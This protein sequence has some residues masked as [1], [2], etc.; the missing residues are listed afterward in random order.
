M[1][2]KN[3]KN[4]VIKFWLHTWKMNGN[5]AINFLFYLFF[6]K[7]GNWNC[8]KRKK[9]K[10]LLTRIIMN[11]WLVHSGPGNK[12]TS[13]LKKDSFHHV[14]HYRTIGGV[15]QCHWLK[16]AQPQKWANP[17][18]NPTKSLSRKSRE[19]HFSFRRFSRVNPCAFK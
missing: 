12:W 4:I 1:R 7:L 16:W 9:F 18:L 13:F 8:G 11:G 19:D 15:F 17:R 2:F 14:G 10:K 5:L 3:K 6:K